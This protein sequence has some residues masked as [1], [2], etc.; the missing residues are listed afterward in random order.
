MNQLSQFTPIPRM[1]NLQIMASG[2]SRVC[3]QSPEGLACFTDNAH[4]A[5]SVSLSSKGGGSEY[6]SFNNDGVVEWGKRPTGEA[7]TTELLVNN[8]EGVSQN[9]AQRRLRTLQAYA[10]S[11][12]Q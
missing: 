10:L 6:L 12:S 7:V 4:G 9:E 2:G 8:G 5:D 3:S 1:Q 11:G